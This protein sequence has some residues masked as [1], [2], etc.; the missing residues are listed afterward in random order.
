[1]TPVSPELKLGF[2][3]TEE[4]RQ[5]TLLTEMVV[6]KHVEGPRKTVSSMARLKPGQAISHANKLPIDKIRAAG[7]R[8]P[9]R[10][11]KMNNTAPDTAAGQQS[12]GGDSLR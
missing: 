8:L 3:T 6:A 11:R 9:A 5:L 4:E 12:S 7:R 10:T 2:T 1:M